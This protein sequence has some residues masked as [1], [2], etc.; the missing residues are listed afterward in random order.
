MR[1]LGQQ[2]LCIRDCFA[3][4]VSLGNWALCAFVLRFLL[5]EE[6]ALFIALMFTCSWFGRTCTTTWRHIILS[7]DSVRYSTLDVYNHTTL[8]WVFYSADTVIMH[9][10]SR[11]AYLQSSD[12]FLRS[13][14]NCAPR[15]CCMRRRS[16][17][18]MYWG[19]P[20]TLSVC[21]GTVS[22]GISGIVQVRSWVR[23]GCGDR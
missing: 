13:S 22:G 18:K 16:R 15:S 3:T 10:F 6:A 7:H 21:V 5:G 4:G 14:I 2:A 20:L 8:R 11:G 23:S 17:R 1:I 19:R 9:A 12:F